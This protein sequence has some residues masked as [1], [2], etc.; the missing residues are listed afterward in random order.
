MDDH[1]RFSG[2]KYE[3]GNNTNNGN[4]YKCGENCSKY[5]VVPRAPPS[6]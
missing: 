1:V 4:H 5:G 6:S 2:T 3:K